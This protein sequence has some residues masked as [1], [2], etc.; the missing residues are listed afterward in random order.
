MN[1]TAQLLTTETDY[2]TFA[3]YSIH[4][5]STIHMVL[6]LRGAG[7]PPVPSSQMTIAAGGLIKQVIHRDY[8][9]DN[10]DT[11]KTTVFNAQMINS[12]KY[13]SVTGIA[14][15]TLPISHATYADNGFPYYSVYEEPSHIHGN[16]GMVKSVGQING[17]D[18]SGGANPPVY[19][20]GPGL[21]VANPKGPLQQFR[22]VADLE[23][24][25]A[26]Y[27]IASF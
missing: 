22:T 23:K 20:A 17:L 3:D 24:E 4:K 27:H 9:L 14:P 5:E 6:R 15:P 2:N 25:M 8:V 21:G 16:F 13:K 1:N 26:N 11:A 18:K 10:W 7:P 12:V 19:D